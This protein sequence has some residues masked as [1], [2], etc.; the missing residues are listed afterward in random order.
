VPRAEHSGPR[1]G[2]THAVAAD[3][4]A[5]DAVFV[6]LADATRRAVLQVVATDGPITATEL[7]ARLPVTRQAVAKHLAILR[8]A[9]LVESQR[10][11][12]ETRFTAASEPLLEA[13]RWLAR[14]QGAWDRRLARLADRA[15]G[16]V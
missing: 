6:A 10:A 11:G 16:R 8:Q 1:A 2:V 13:S 12:R 3:D 15:A 5:P 7:A 4:S 14:T 9:G